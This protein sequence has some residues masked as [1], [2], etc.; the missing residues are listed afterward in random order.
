MSAKNL[1]LKVLFVSLDDRVD[2]PICP[3]HLSLIINPSAID[4]YQGVMRLGLH[5]ARCTNVPRLGHFALY[6]EL[7]RVCKA[8]GNIF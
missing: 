2:I 1:T 8:I 7:D 4:L 6:S 3:Y 5:M